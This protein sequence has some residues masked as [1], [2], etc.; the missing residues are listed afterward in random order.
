MEWWQT[1]V[2][3][4]AGV[5]T[6]FNLGDKIISWVKAMKKPQDDI[7]LRVTRLEKLI[8]GEY[9]MLFN[10]FEARFKRDLERINEIEKSNK[11]TQKSLLALM[12]HAIDGNNIDKLKKVAD[13]LSDYIV[14]K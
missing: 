1:T 10:D 3:I 11:L 12:R 5:L 2:V 4:A 13:E 8:E 7:E 6:L 9:K 14:D